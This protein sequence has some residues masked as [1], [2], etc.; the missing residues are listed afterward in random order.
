MRRILLAVLL[1][2]VSLLAA[3]SYMADFVVVNESD[4]PIE[5]RYKVGE[6]SIDPFAVNGKPATLPAS[7]LNASDRQWR[8]LPPAQY[9]F[10]RESRRVTAPLMPGEGLRVTRQKD[11][12]EGTI[13]EIKFPVE[14]INIRGAHGELTLTGDQVYKSF[15][16]QSQT[17]C[18]LT[19]R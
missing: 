2:S 13:I 4:E 1:I 7:R 17:L 6:T 12:G 5:V 19:Y 18:T 9:A 16:I 3:C 8:E 14:E 10:N 15:V 11:W